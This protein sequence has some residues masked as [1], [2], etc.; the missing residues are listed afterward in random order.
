MFRRDYRK[1]SG[2]DPVISDTLLEGTELS[3]GEIVA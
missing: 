1:M 2:L 3:D